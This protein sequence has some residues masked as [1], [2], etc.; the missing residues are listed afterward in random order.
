MW[1]N[2]PV[3]GTPAKDSDTVPQ[4][5]SRLNAN[6]VQSVAAK[7]LLLTITRIIRVLCTFLAMETKPHLCALTVRPRFDFLEIVLICEI[8]LMMK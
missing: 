8:F 5:L 7:G 1:T 3:A 2:C 4:I 6:Q